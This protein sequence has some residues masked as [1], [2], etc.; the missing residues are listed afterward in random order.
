[1]VWSKL[2]NK[3]MPGNFFP[4][5]K[6]TT[7]LGKCAVSLM[8]AI[9]VSGCGSDL[10]DLDAL[11][12][13]S[14]RNNSSNYEVTALLS[15]DQVVSPEAVTSDSAGEALLNINLASNAING[16]VSISSNGNSTIQQVQIRKGFGGQ[17][18]NVVL[19]LSPDAVNSA[20]WHVPD[21]YLL[22]NEDVELLMR[23]GLYVLVT[24]AK[25]VNGE[26]RGQLLLGGQEILINPLVAEQVVSSNS[27]SLVTGTSYLSVDFVTGEIQGSI[28]HSVDISP[29]QISIHAGLAGL[30][31]EVI[32][33]YAIDP[34]EPGV[35]RIPENT[36]LAEDLLERLYTAQVYVQ[37]YSDSHPE[38][39][40]RGQLHLFHY[41]VSVTAL[42][43]SSLI[44]EI[45]TSASGKA[46]LTL[47][48][49]DDNA[50]AIVR[51][52]DITPLNV[53]L[54]RASSPNSTEKGKLLHEFEANQD[55]WQLPPG[56]VFSRIEY[57]DIANGKLM[58]IVT[59]AEYPL[60][61][62]GGRI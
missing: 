30:E 27:D 61:E 56:I 10:S 51:V 41:S 17:N 14:T 35:W 44:P 15:V 26:L 25:H 18:G 37:V 43:G 13:E 3:G 1:M 12:K 62:I 21:N 49:Y 32:V 58:F 46:Y 24:S 40:I 5:M 23:G 2:N 9:F 33:D 11:A 8:L 50:Q 38:G 34:S 45:A 16:Q 52:S 31:G 48:G 7:G 42:S 59:S 28:R 55:Y 19:N 39:E 53:M 6:F 60:G 22:S 57:N 29:T 4:S 47:N 20:Q 36:V 54:F